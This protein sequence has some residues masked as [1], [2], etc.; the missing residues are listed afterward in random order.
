[1]KLHGLVAGVTPAPAAM[2]VSFLLC[3]L[4]DTRRAVPTSMGVATPTEHVE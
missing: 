1:M 4:P 2:F 3:G